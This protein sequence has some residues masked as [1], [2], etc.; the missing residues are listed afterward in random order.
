MLTKLQE[1]VHLEESQ[2]TEPTGVS[3]ISEKNS[4]D[5]T[6]SVAALIH[7]SKKATSHDA[8]DCWKLP[9]QR[10]KSGS[11]SSSNGSHHPT[12]QL[13]EVDNSHESD[14]SLLLTEAA[15]QPIIIDSGA[16]HH[17]INNP[18]MICY[19]GESS[20]QT[21]Y[22]GKHTFGP[23]LNLVSHLHSATIQRKLVII[24][25]TDRGATI[26]LNNNFKIL[27][28][29]KKNF[30][31]SP[32]WHEHLGQTNPKYQSMMVLNSISKD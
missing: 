26:I 27:G 32:K 10:P 5:Q 18:E 22:S 16:T 17:L 20:R 8:D 15:S 31:D 19:S 23:Y 1:I 2:K 29:M 7:E 30:Q 21:Y 28:S 3:K 14:V 11:K 6:N 4:E 24:K 9:E 13:V 25:I 12:T